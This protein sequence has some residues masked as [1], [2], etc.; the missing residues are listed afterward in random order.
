MQRT[1]AFSREM[2]AMAQ[3]TAAPPD[4][5]SFI[6]SMFSAG[7][8]EMPP[9]SNVMPFPTSPSTVP[10]TACFGSWRSTMTTRRFLAAARDAEQHAHLQLG[11]LLLVEDLDVQAGGLGDLRGPLGEDARRQA[12]ARLVRQLA[13]HVRRLAEDAP[14]LGGLLDRGRRTRRPAAPRFRASTRG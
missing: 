8:I 3:M 11:N 12:V 10:F 1:G 5:S 2:A 13:R 7:L 9:V 14:A 4:M 6:L